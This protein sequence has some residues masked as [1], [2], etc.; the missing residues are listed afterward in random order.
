MVDGEVDVSE[1]SRTKV[2]VTVATLDV[3]VSDRP[4]AVDGL[5]VTRL[6]V[7]DVDVTVDRAA[8]AVTVVA[9]VT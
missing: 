3:E 8:G 5:T 6:V 7:V 9:S 2:E 1:V 4:G